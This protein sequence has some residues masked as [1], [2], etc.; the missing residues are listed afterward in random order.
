MTMLPPREQQALR[1]VGR[2]AISAPVSWALVLLFLMTIA[3][4]GLLEPVVEDSHHGGAAEEPAGDQSPGLWREFAAGV[5]ASFRAIRSEGLITANHQLQL[6]MDEFEVR[7]DEESFLRRV[8]L[9]PLQGFLS[10]YLGVGNEQAYLGRSDWLFYRPD[11]DYVTGRGFLEEDVQRDRILQSDPWADPPQPDPIPALRQ[12]EAELQ[13]RGV[14]LL[15]LPTPVKPV[16]EPGSFSRRFSAGSPPL[17]NP[18]YEEFCRRLGDNGIDFLD[19]APDLWRMRQAGSEPQYL[20]TDTHWAPEAVEQVALSLSRRLIDRGLT[21]K[22]VAGAYFQRQGEVENLGDIARMLTPTPAQTERWRQRVTSHRVVDASGRPWRSDPRAEVL[23]LGD[24]F[25][26]IYSDPSL[27][28]GIGAG[29]AEQLSFFLQKPVDKIAL[30]AGGALA[31]RRALRRHRLGST[32]RLEGKR[33]VIYQ[34]AVRELR[35]GDWRLLGVD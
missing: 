34:F 3:S 24:S 13:A 7:L 32:G 35:Q 29:L 19:V 25:S 31:A 8:V 21:G 30:N 28:W 22:P 11:V 33:V 15:L 5:S 4:V 16:L 18:S 20:R 1:E 6:T 27:G 10:S 12:L 26:N 23:L 2:T 9:P 17:Q 14:H